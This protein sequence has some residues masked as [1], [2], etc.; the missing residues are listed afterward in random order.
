MLDFH[1]PLILTHLCLLI[2]LS[3]KNIPIKPWKFSVTLTL[4]QEKKE[5]SEK[6][7]R[8]ESPLGGK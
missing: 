1:R 5:K 4:S 3:D 7:D 8:Y 2:L 6:M